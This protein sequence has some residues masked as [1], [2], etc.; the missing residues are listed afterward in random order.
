MD[1]VPSQPGVMRNTCNQQVTVRWCSLSYD[2]HACGNGNLGSADV[3][4]GG[5]AVVDRDVK[6]HLIACAAPTR[7]TDIE[8]TP[9]NGFLYNCT[10]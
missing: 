7:P 5:T 3:P 6:I 10:Q 1:E 9:G 8:Y 2:T 4:P